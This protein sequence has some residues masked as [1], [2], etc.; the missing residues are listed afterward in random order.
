MRAFTKYD[1]ESSARK[2]DAW[3]YTTSRQTPPLRKYECTHPRLLNQDNSVMIT[4]AI[5][6]KNAVK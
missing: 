2:S 4:Y 6:Q 1:D 3:S 5:V